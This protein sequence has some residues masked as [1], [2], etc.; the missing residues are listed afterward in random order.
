[1]KYICL[2]YID[3]NTFASFSEAEQHAMVDSCCAYDDQQDEQDQPRHSPS[4]FS[5][6]TG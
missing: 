4:S 5:C 1:M 2:G 6:V 3:P